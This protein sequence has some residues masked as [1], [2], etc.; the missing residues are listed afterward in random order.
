MP[1]MA[2]L[3]P[4]AWP[5]T[6]IRTERLLRRRDRVAAQREAVVVGAAGQD[7]CV[8]VVGDQRLAHRVDTDRLLRVFRCRRGRSSGGP[9]GP[10]R[11]RYEPFGR[12]PW[13]A[14]LF[15]RVFLLLVRFDM[16]DSLVR[17]VVPPSPPPRP[18]RHN[19]SSD[20]V[21]A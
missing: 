8:R 10:S 9:A 1:A 21:R 18:A 13:F 14:P 11:R 16:A 15:L 3:G 12:L 17:A 20:A 7:A 5:P 19:R 2:D 4:V 6:P